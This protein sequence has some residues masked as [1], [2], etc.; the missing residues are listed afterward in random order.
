VKVTD[1]RFEETIERRVIVEEKIKK[2]VIEKSLEERVE[3][4]ESKFEEYCYLSDEQIKQIRDLIQLYYDIY[5]NKRIW[6]ILRNECKFSKLERVPR[7]K[8][9]MI[10][11]VLYDFVGSHEPKQEDHPNPKQNYF[12]GDNGKLIKDEI[13]F[14]ENRKKKLYKK[15]G[16]VDTSG[17]PSILSFTFSEQ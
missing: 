13:K 2:R 9:H 12:L 10:T 4:L 16:V 14:S 15:R 5:G 6:S 3:M 7:Y 1:K 17:C 11:R 8:F